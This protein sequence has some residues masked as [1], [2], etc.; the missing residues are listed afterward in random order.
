MCLFSDVNARLAWQRYRVVSASS[1]IRSLLL[2][3]REPQLSTA[4]VSTRISNVKLTAQVNMRTLILPAGITPHDSV[5]VLLNHSGWSVSSQTKT[6][7]TLATNSLTTRTNYTYA[8]I[9][10]YIYIPICPKNV[11]SYNGTYKWNYFLENKAFDVSTFCESKKG[12]LD[13]LRERPM[14]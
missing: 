9:G 13:F 11:I 7:V 5:I 1:G 4:A 14:H 8:H 10:K 12:V 3:Q 6:F 2:V